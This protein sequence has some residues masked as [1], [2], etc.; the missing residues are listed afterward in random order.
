MQQ[1]FFSLPQS[2]P[3]FIFSMS[4]TYILSASPLSSGLH[5]IL[6]LLLFLFLSFSQCPFSLQWHTSRRGF[7]LFSLEWFFIQRRSL[8]LCL[9]VSPPPY[10]VRL[11]LSSK[12]MFSGQCQFCAISL[13]LPPS[14]PPSLSLSIALLLSLQRAHQLKTLRCVY[15]GTHKPCGEKLLQRVC[16]CVCVAGEF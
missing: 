10:L 14:L 8:H 5:F 11:W 4:S 7:H 2:A 1:N 12:S 6:T 13:S 3:P 9:Y 16:V 15:A